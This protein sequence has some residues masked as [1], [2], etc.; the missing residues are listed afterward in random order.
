MIEIT[1][2]GEFESDSRVFNNYII[3]DLNGFDIH[4]YKFYC[5]EFCLIDD[6]FK[7]HVTIKPPFCLDSKPTTRL[8]NSIEWQ[9]ST[10]GFTYDDGDVCYAEFLESTWK[11]LQNRKIV[12]TSTEKARHLKIIF[13]YFCD[14]EY[15][16]LFNLGFELRPTAPLEFCNK[17][18]AGEKIVF[19][20]CALTVASELEKLVTNNLVVIDILL[21]TMKIQTLCHEYLTK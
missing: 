17:H 8:R 11:R 9:V 13:S 16:I 3:V 18:N 4:Y 5:K 20:H 15:I 12:V 7:Y 19:G 2:S 14:F 1:A 10:A 6:K 21:S